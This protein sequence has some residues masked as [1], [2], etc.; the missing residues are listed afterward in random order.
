MTLHKQLEY[1]VIYVPVSMCPGQ[2]RLPDALD[3]IEIVLVLVKV[4][5]RK[6]KGQSNYSSRNEAPA[7]VSWTIK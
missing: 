6:Y 4:V 7:H 2:Y 1:I 3:I 5:V